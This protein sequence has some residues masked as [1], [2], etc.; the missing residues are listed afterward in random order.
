M[1]KARCDRAGCDEPQKAH[2]L[3]QRHYDRERSS[4]RGPR[5]RED[6]VLTTRAR[7]RA[8][9]RMIA[10]HPEEFDR[11]YH[12]C[13][14]KV[15]AEDA[16]LRKVAAQT[17]AEPTHDGQILRLK[18]GPAAEDEEIVDRIDPAPPPCELCSTYHDAE[19]H[20][21][22]CDATPSRLVDDGSGFNPMLVPADMTDER[23]K[24]AVERGKRQSKSYTEDDYDEEE[25]A[26]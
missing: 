22:H 19:H 3:C 1:G 12:E 15:Q 9:A 8:V 26:E 23:I 20:C 18:R 13:L 17:G 24:A 21:L 25:A 6:R 2:G 7:N 11:L 5:R 10:K 14:A 4:A 16:E